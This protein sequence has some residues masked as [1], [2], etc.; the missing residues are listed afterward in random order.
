VLADQELR[1]DL[2]RRGGETV[3]RYSWDEAARGVCRVFA[4]VLQG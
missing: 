2:R 3:A 4:S 1:S